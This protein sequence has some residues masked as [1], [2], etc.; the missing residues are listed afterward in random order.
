MIFSA[1]SRARVREAERLWI[2]KLVLRVVTLVL[3]LVAIGLVA[4]SIAFLTSSPYSL[5]SGYS[6]IGYRS[7]VDI[8]WPLIPVSQPS[9]NL[10]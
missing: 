1:E 6:Q 8:A 2:A 3:V 10:P 7:S 5:P 9:T 4:S